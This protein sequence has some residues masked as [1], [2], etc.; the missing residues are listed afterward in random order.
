VP[1]PLVSVIFCV[2]N[3]E[4]TLARAL[5]SVLAQNFSGAEVVVVDDGSTDGTPA[6][7]ARYAARIGIVRQEN[8]G[9]AAARNA[10]VAASRGAYVAFIDADDVYLP[11][12][13][14]QTVAALER[15]S[16]AVLA[17]ADALPVD[18][19]DRP[20]STSFVPRDSAHAPSM[21]EM[22]G[23]W[24]PIL[25][26]AVTIRR[27]TFDACAGFR[28]EY[29]GASGFEDVLFFM[30]AREQGPF[31][32]VPEPL[33]RY[34]LAPFVERM[35]KYAPGF[36]LFARHVRERYGADGDLRIRRQA[37]G[38]ARALS[39]GGMRALA[40]GDRPRARAAIRCALRYRL[41]RREIFRLMKTGLPT[42]LAIALSSRK[43]RSAGKPAADSDA[44][45]D[46]L[47]AW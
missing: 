6:I 7:L 18:N 34:L 3:G 32:Y 28:E 30:M 35:S 4:S 8:R 41:S 5:D 31:V 24:W 26:S 10:G 47:E 39:A 20:L 2:Y 21:D 44:A 13:L 25:P 43:W 17:Y 27:R 42:P 40:Q 15:E 23:R 1:V 14:A 38:L 36:K 46:G 12:R 29:R 16:A 9:L 33:V 37:E 22:I 11:G 45:E 19:L